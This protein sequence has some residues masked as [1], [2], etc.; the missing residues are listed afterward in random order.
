MKSWM[1]EGL[2]FLLSQQLCIS[3]SSLLVLSTIKYVDV[4]SIKLHLYRHRFVEKYFTKYYFISERSSSGDLYAG[5][6]VELE[7]AN[8]Y[9]KWS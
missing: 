2:L 5:A 4:E 1:V 6:Q 9:R 7:Y 3:L 8:P